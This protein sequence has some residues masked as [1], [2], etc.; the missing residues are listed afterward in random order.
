MYWAVEDG[1][2][3]VAQ[4]RLFRFYD[5]GSKNG[6]EGIQISFRSLS[7]HFPHILVYYK[8]I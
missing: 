5:Q 4:K 3:L 1:F 7:L 8:Y 2:W 6:E